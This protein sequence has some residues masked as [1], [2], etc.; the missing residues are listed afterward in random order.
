MT[1]GWYTAGST[2]ERR[3]RGNGGGLGAGGGGGDGSGDGGGGGGALERRPEAHS[4]RAPP[5]EEPEKPAAVEDRT[6]L[7]HLHGLGVAC[8]WWRGARGVVGGA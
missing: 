2:Q 1:G 6:T 3:G 7:V 4:P 5:V 8:R